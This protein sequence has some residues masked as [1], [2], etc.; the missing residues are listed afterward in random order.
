MNSQALQKRIREGNL[1]SHRP[2]GE[3]PLSEVRPSVGYDA[4]DDDSAGATD[5]RRPESPG[6]SMPNH[7]IEI[8]R[9]AHAGFWG[10]R[11]TQISRRAVRSAQAS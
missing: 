8:L 2:T 11:Q 1:N 3:W 9:E 10:L 6:S 5:A 4:D 7:R